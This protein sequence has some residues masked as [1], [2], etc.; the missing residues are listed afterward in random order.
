VAGTGMMGIAS[1]QTGDTGSPC[2]LLKPNQKLSS[3]ALTEN[4]FDM[5][6]FKLKR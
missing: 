4:R 6:F 3:H 2:L 1:S 5:N